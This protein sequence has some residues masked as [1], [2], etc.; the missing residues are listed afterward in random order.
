MS[1]ETKD[2]TLLLL[3]ALLSTSCINDLY[4]KPAYKVRQYEVIRHNS[5][6]QELVCE[7]PLV[8]AKKVADILEKTYYVPTGSVSKPKALRARNL[9]RIQV[10]GTCEQGY[11]DLPQYCQEIMSS[12]PGSHTVVEVDSK[13]RFLRVFVALE[14]CIKAAQV[15]QESDSL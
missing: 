3:D 7:Y 5:N 13:N 10:H 1:L 8:S 14:A 4:I 6:L 15:L 2:R 9:A 12:N 11:G